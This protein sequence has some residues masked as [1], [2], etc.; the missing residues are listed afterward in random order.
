MYTKDEL[1]IVDYV[2]NEKPKSVN[3]VE[4][5]KEQ[6]KLAATTKYNKRK[7]INIKVLESDID[8]FKAKA[9]VEGMPYQTLINSILHKYIT[10]QL[11]DKNL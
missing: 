4:H 3:N 8:R 5:K 7:A 6:L 10:G 1:D 2:E 11:I 9:L